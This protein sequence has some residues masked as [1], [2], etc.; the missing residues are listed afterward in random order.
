MAV[1]NILTLHNFYEG[2]KNDTLS[3]SSNYGIGKP[4][5]FDGTKITW[6]SRTIHNF[7]FEELV[8]FT[9][10]DIQYGLHFS[11]CHFKKGI[12]FR[13]IKN[14]LNTSTEDDLGG[15]ISFINCSGKYIKFERNCNIP[16]GIELDKK[17]NIENLFVLQSEIKNG[18]LKI[19]DSS[20]SNLLDISI[21]KFEL[22]IGNSE[23]KTLRVE[24][25]IGDISIVKSK[26]TDW[27]KFWNVECSNSFTL[28]YN[29]FEDSFEIKVSRINRLNIH[30]DTFKRKSLFENRNNTENN[31]SSNLNEIY[32][33][34]ANFTE[35]FE[36]DGMGKKLSKITLPFSLSCQGV[37]KINNWKINETIISGINQNLKLLFNKIDFKRI[38]LNEFSN[39]GVV[40]FNE[41]SADNTNFNSADDPD[42]SII[43]SNSSFGNTKF[44]EFDFNSF[45]FINTSNVSFEGIEASNVKWFADNK[46]QINSLLPADEKGYRRKRELY[47]QIKQTLRSKGN[48]IDSLVFQAR[49]MQA[50]RNELKKSKKYG[51]QDRIIMTVNQTNNY[52]MNW[53]KPLT[54][55]L[56]STLVCYALFL[57]LFSK[58]MEYNLNNDLISCSEY[59]TEFKSKLP[60]LAQ[61]LNP[62]RRFST[63][64]GENASTSLYFFD[65][66]HRVVLGILIF[67][68]IK[69]FRRL[70]SK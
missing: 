50:Y 22:R 23:I 17:T 36:F 19:N 66:F 2:L 64:Y 52:G 70:S 61:M 32:I 29:T 65:L 53:L 69:A 6:E 31:I 44:S 40:N 39:F 27:A 33:T 45:N 54:L 57:P 15:G 48:Q 14:S 4:L 56:L 42:S 37:L 12:S 20:I 28:N 1:R 16:R 7:T 8:S 55:I 9:D 34:D 35:S 38:V 13:N 47:R 18:G 21:G 24:S 68:L 51:L 59:F 5:N 41:C 30:G 62:A 63:T 49:E 11:N 58:I 43:I 10:L 60:A 46:L 67:Q 26:F 3:A 25:L